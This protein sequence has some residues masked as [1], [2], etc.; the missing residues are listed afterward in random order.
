MRLIPL[1]DRVI[2]QPIETEEKLAGGLLLPENSKEKQQQGIVIA[3]AE[4]Y[5]HQSGK[6]VPS[7]VQP[8][9]KVIYGLYSATEVK[10]GGVKYL[11]MREADIMAIVQ[12][13]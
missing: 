6:I 2:V 3:C 12:E 1:G 8:G 4:E 13:E 7:I 10:V 11:I 9:D 5:F